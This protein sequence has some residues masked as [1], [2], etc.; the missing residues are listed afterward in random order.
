M[1]L[2][3]A[4]SEEIPSTTLAPDAS[5]PTRPPPAPTPPPT[6]NERDKMLAACIGAVVTSLTMTPFDVIKTR[7][8]T[9]P[10]PSPAVA[11][12]TPSTTPFP[13]PIASTSTAPPPPSASEAA[14]CDARK[15]TTRRA[16]PP[17]VQGEGVWCALESR[18]AAARGRE[19]AYELAS[20]SSAGAGATLTFPTSSG[21]NVACLYPSSSSARAFPT[22]TAHPPPPAPTRHLTGFVDA[23]TH[24][25]RT[26]GLTALWRGTAPA[27]AMSVPGQVVYMVGY[28]SLRRTALDRAPGF[29]YVGE[30]SGKGTREGLRKGYVGAVPLVAGALSRTLVATLLSPLELLRTQ[31]QSHT[32]SSPLSLTSVIRD[33]R[34]SNAWKGLGPTLWRDV[35]F[36]GVYWAG[37]EVI[38]RALTGGRGMGEAVAQSGGGE[39]G[40]G[41][42]REFVVSFVSGAGS[43]VIAATLTNPFD[44]LKTRRQSSL[45]SSPSSASRSA[46]STLRLLR[47]LVHSEGPRAM[48]AGLA[49]RLAKVG[50]A[51]GV[52][53]GVYEVVGGWRAGV[54]AREVKGEVRVE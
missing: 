4:L 35:P 40:G 5:I 37:Y 47:Q 54:H 16:P 29:A 39:K 18:V 30:G 46:P 12:F 26:E 53:I 22:S 10:S 25:L 52:M 51:C 45:L 6:T 17:V 38:K 7:L 8:Q 42:G 11:R 9:Q 13:P 21:G 14:C 3:N 43:G 50:P 27:L 33:L 19:W 34:W 44:V 32:P 41:R 36:S 48:F 31:L 1:L 15:A 24:I 2:E 20:A 49:P 23:L 28:D